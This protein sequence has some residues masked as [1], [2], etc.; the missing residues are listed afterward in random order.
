MPKTGPRYNFCMLIRPSNEPKKKK[1][2]KAFLRNGIVR[3]LPY[4][5]ISRI[6][7]AKLLDK[8]YETLRKISVQA[9][10]IIDIF[11]YF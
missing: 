5:V 2:N 7:G 1:I 3:F 10:H 11:E 4:K 8:K 9:K 6:K